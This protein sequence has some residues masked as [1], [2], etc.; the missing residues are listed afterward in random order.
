MTIRDL[1]ISLKS[2]GLDYKG[3]RNELVERFRQHSSTK[4]SGIQVSV[5]QIIEK[6]DFFIFLEKIYEGI[7]FC[8]S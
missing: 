4:V 1:K 5:V 8:R 2:I 7:C 6:G 3:T